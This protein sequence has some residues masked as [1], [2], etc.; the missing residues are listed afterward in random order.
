MKSRPKLVDAF[1]DSIIFRLICFIVVLTAFSGFLIHILEPSHF[2]TWFDGIWW[3]I[4]TIF[5]VGYGDF[6]PHTLI[7]KLIG[8]GIILFGTGFCSYYMVL[9]ATDM[10]NKQYMK[11]KGEEAA[12]SNGHM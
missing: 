7:G 2:T 8:M 4:V 12:T 5:T 3:S 9:F 6:A 10:I 11:V 1:R